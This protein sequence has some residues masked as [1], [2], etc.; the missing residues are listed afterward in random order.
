MRRPEPEEKTESRETHATHGGAERIESSNLT[1]AH[2]AVATDAGFMLLLVGLNERCARG[3][4][5]GE[6]EEESAEFRPICIRDEAGDHADRA[7]RDEAD[8]P[9][10]R[11][12]AFDCS[13]PGVDDHGPTLRSTRLRVKQR[14]RSATMR[15]LR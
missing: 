10:V 3:E 13:E 9:L 7:T 8:D 2:C 6:G 5:G 1:A 15:E 12:D 4:D 11:L 14:T